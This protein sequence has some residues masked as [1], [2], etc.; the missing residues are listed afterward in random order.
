VLEVAATVSRLLG[1]RAPERAR[2]RVLVPVEDPGVGVARPRA[3]AAAPA[4]GGAE[5]VV[6][7]GPSW[8]GLGVQAL[9][10][11]A[12]RGRCLA[13]V[14]AR[15]EEAAIGDVIAG[16]P[17][18]ACG[19]PVDV[20][21][22]DD[23]SS[24]RTPDIGREHG[25]RVLSHP[26][27]RGLGAALRTGLEIARDEGYD[28]A[29]YLDGDGEY[30]PA[31]FARVLEPVAR[32][33]ADY[34]LGSRFLGSR[35]GMSWHRTLANRTTS[36]LVGFLT[37]TVTSDGQTGY[38]A[39]SARALAAARIAHDYNYAQVLTLSL[40]GHGIEP[41]EVPISYRRRTSG[42]SFVRYPEYFA[43][44]APAV[45][46]EWR[47]AK[48]SRATSAA[49]PTPTAAASQ[50]GH[51]PSG[52]NNGSTSV[53]GPNGASGLSAANEPPPQRTSA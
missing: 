25:A 28:A 46:R 2:G 22:V 33:R 41:V 35:D 52:V 24:D 31:D 30:P 11:T 34:V 42:R 40:W 10:R 18:E 43:R 6:P 23:G 37:H 19:L 7:A 39:F 45:W 8:F 13:V 49:T 44:V 51:P 38:R 15:N 47:A 32:G 3:A 1:V 12:G 9:G 27:S 50:N 14:V 5:R 36:A 29:V 17:R 26:A 16:L 53:S 4:N 21:L 48:A 20:L